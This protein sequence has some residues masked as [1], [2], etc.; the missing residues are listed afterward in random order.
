MVETLSFDVKGLGLLGFSLL[1]D[2]SFWSLPRFRLSINLW[3]SV[4]IFWRIFACV[5]SPLATFG[6]GSRLYSLNRFPSIRGIWHYHSRYIHLYGLL[7]LNWHG[8]NS[9]PWCQT[10]DAFRGLHTGWSIS[11]IHSTLSLP[12][13]IWR[14]L[15]SLCM[16]FSWQTVRFKSRLPT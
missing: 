6:L 13:C 4:F 1:V 12:F 11:L 3:G 7:G 16:S 5:T 9:F 8:L 15:K 14:H 2:P 10:L